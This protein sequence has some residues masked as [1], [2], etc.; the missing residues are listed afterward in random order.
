MHWLPGSLATQVR[1]AIGPLVNRG[2]P[3][4][5]D[6]L[7]ASASPVQ[8][9]RPSAALRD[10]L[11]WASNTTSFQPSLSF[12]TGY[13]PA[14]MTALSVGI[15][16]GTANSGNQQAGI[17]VSSSPSSNSF[18]LGARLID[19]AANGQASFSVQ[20]SDFSS[21]TVGPISHGVSTSGGR[22][23]MGVT[24]RRNTTAGLRAFVN[25]VVVGSANSSNLALFPSS[26]AVDVHVATGGT[27]NQGYLTTVNALWARALSDDEMRVLSDNP[28]QLFEP[29]PSSFWAPS[30]AAAIFQLIADITT[31]G[32]TAVGAA[33]VAA[34]TNEAVPSDAEYGLSPNLSS[35]Y[36]GSI[37]SMPAGT[38]TV[39]F[40]AD[41]TTAQGQMRIRYLDASNVDVGGTAW[42]TLTGTPT[43]YSLTATT[44]AT[45]TRARIEVQ[46]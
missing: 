10:G 40:R 38:Y 16:N 35:S 30:A 20:Y 42:Q 44:T 43:T 41:R 15:I 2:S 24:W 31:N 13:N 25:G 45:A 4:A 18:A 1:Q 34:A 22:L 36:T 19:F 33:S 23:V 17:R 11:G 27:N 8:H 14:G 37:P 29:P 21:Q 26:M 7:Y 28:W 6:L 3:L 12:P 32:W 39:Q 46:P 9:G 5:R